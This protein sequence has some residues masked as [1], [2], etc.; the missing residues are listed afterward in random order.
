MTLTWLLGVAGAGLESGAPHRPAEAKAEGRKPHLD[1]YGDPLPAQARGRLGTLRFR[2]I[3][4]GGGETF[5]EALAYSPNGKVLFSLGFDGSLCAWDAASGRCLNHFGRPVAGV[6]S[7]NVSP[8]GKKVGVFKGMGSSVWDVTTGK[9]VPLRR[10][11]LGRK[12]I[13]E[14]AYSPD[15]RSI[16]F[17]RG[18]IHLRDAAT[19]RD[20]RTFARKEGGAFW[21]VLF[22]RDSRT[23]LGGGVTPGEHFVVFWDVASGKELR[24]IQSPQ[25]HFHSA[26]LALSPDGKVLATGGVPIRL[27]DSATARELF[28]VGGNGFHIAFAPDGRTLA[29]WGGRSVDLIETST[30]KLRSRLKGFSRNRTTFAFSPD[31]RTVALNDDTGGIHLVDLAS[32]KEVRASEGHSGAVL[33]LSLSADG[34]VLATAGADG[35]ARVWDVARGRELR[36]VKTSQR[37]L[38]A[39]SLSP[40]GKQ[41]AAVDGCVRVW[42][43]STGREV[44]RFGTEGAY[45]MAV[46]FAPDGKGLAASGLGD[47]WL[48]DVASGK[49][50]RRFKDGGWHGLAFSPRGDVLV[51]GTVRVWRVATGELVLDLKE[52]GRARPFSLCPDGRSLVLGG[53]RLSNEITLYEM[54]TREQRH[55]FKTA[56]TGTI[57]LA[58]DGRL[59]AIAADSDVVLWNLVAEKEVTRLKGHR[60]LVTSLAFSADGKTL[61]SGSADSTVLLSDLSLWSRPLPPG[62]GP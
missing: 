13:G 62:P 33:N 24:R 53:G 16:A 58:P 11:W 37:G 42:D 44:R 2:H 56:H 59:L 9:E 35:T 40:D 6:S 20:L 23:L 54:L 15:G 12:E 41:L 8:D 32:G 3:G 52:V 14:V 28:A 30:G 34:K 7:L 25:E 31:N 47:T 43:V 38:S 55:R 1:R 29:S 60:G 50:L 46:A 18:L 51:T 39:V 22:S 61:F 5:V 26:H 17:A 57:A 45:Y 49:E 48:W 4:F 21:A 10:P 19:D 36:R 27:W